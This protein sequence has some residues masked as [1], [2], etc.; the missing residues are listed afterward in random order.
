[1]I[2]RRILHPTPREKKSESKIEKRN[3]RRKER[4]EKIY[5]GKGKKELKKTGK[6]T[7][8]MESV[9]KI[10]LGNCVAN[11]LVMHSVLQTFT[12]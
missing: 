5:K 2:L 9:A 10:A 8:V 3:E 7:L 11:T 6:K 4:I 1:M 12:K